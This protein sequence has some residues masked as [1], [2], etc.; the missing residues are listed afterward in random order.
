MH[1]ESCSVFLARP[2]SEE[3]VLSVED[4]V[5][6]QRLV[7]GRVAVELATV[8]PLPTLSHLEGCTKM[9]VRGIGR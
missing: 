9:P 1:R 4:S 6:C 3:L 8:L 7:D 5:S 2:P